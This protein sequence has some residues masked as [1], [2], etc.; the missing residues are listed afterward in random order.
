M[1]NETA[2]RAQKGQVKLVIFVGLCR[3]RLSQGTEN[4]GTGSLL[5]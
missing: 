1:E 4:E 3:M 5:L 2:R